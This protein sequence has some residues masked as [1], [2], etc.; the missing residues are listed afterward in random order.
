MESESFISRN[1]DWL[2]IVALLFGFGITWYM[3]W[4]DR[5]REKEEAKGAPDR[6]GIF[7]VYLLVT[8]MPVL[9][10]AVIHMLLV[11]FEREPDSMFSYVPYIL[12]SSIGSIV[13]FFG[14]LKRAQVK[15]KNR[16]W[17]YLFLLLGFIT[18]LAFFINVYRPLTQS[19]VQLKTVDEIHALPPSQEFFNIQ[20]FVPHLDKLYDRVTTSQGSKPRMYYLGLVPLA[21][22]IHPDTVYSIWVLFDDSQKLEGSGSE[23]ELSTFK[24][25]GRSMA[26]TYDYNNVM[27]FKRYQ[28]KNYNVFLQESGITKKPITILTPSTYP[29]SMRIKDDIYIFI[30]VYVICALAFLL[31]VK[32]DSSDSDLDSI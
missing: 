32:T 31:F 3:K 20:S 2:I 14:R 8:L 23:R 24:E 13:I 1:Y 19:I 16:F 25:E 17:V 27:Y 22:P 26:R 6:K 28:R 7:V 5:K 29:L 15:A 30:G 21:S 12:L 18:P 4:V 11:K 10:M 9:L